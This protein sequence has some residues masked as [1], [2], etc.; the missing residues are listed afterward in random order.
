M[1][2]WDK[3]YSRMIMSRE[4]NTNKVFCKYYYQYFRVNLR[5]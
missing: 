2:G 5:L 4:N 1:K 3:H